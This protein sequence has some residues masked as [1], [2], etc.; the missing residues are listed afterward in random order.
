MK[1]SRNSECSVSLMAPVR[2][3]LTELLDYIFEFCCCDKASLFTPRVND[4]PT[5]TLSSVC[6][7]W[8]EIILP[9]PKFWA[10]LSLEHLESSVEEFDMQDSRWVE[11]SPVETVSSHIED[12]FGVS[13][14]SSPAC[15]NQTL[16]K[17]EIRHL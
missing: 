9:N 13:R 4:G 6:A 14:T 1:G 3:L 7:Q 2:K 12:L 8:R 17:M 16:Y 10:N 11:S 5:F 15:I